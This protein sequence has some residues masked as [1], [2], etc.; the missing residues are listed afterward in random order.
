[1]V[2]SVSPS[3]DQRVAFDELLQRSAGD[4]ETIKQMAAYLDATTGNL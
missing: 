3:E 2:D 4:D 1:M